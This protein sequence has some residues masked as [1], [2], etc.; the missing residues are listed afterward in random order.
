MSTCESSPPLDVLP[1]LSEPLVLDLKALNLQRRL[2][3]LH[4]QLLRDLSSD[5][6]MPF[7]YTP[8]SMRSSRTKSRITVGETQSRGPMIF[9]TNFPSRSTT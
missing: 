4:R 7:P 3:E 9:A 2:T 8:S 5:V 6:H 1:Q